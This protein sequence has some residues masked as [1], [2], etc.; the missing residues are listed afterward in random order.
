[1]VSRLAP[2]ETNR[3]Q[4]AACQLTELDDD[5]SKV[6]RMPR[7]IEEP[8]V[9]DGG[10]V[11]AGAE[12][13]P[14][15]IADALHGEAHGEEQ[16]AGDVAAGAEGMLR[17]ALHGGR[18]DHGDGQRDQPDPEHLEDP[19]AQ[20]GQEAVA[21]VVEAVVL[22]RLEDAEEQEAREP[23]GPDHEEDGGDDLPRIVVAA[24][25]EG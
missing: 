5:L 2:R 12:A 1:M 22:A 19:E 8:P 16:H 3:R 24:E 25:R 20:E 7:H 23:Q 14:L 9:A 11:V 4:A 15:H 21:L 13:V 6:V 10:P 17:V 18:V